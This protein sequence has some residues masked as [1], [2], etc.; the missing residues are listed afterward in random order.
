MGEILS[1]EI[2]DHTYEVRA[3]TYE[4]IRSTNHSFATIAFHASPVKKKA[5]LSGAEN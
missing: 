5:P 4:K 2:G 3:T 1:E